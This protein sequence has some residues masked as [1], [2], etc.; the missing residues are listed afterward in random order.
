MSSKL[1]R[2][3]CNCQSRVTWEDSLRETV[4]GWPVGPDCGGIV[5]IELVDG[6]GEM[7]EFRLQHLHPAA[8]SC[9]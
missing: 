6:A 7:T 2:A 9:L 4:L 1:R 8:L 5:S 3:S